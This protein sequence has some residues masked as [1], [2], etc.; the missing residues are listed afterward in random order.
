MAGCAR[1]G[2]A[3][4]RAYYP[5]SLCGKPSG[6]FARVPRIVRCPE[7]RAAYV[8]AYRVNYDLG[9]RGDVRDTVESEAWIERRLA[10]LD[11]QRKRPGWSA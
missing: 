8:R 4:N 3:V 11:R 5:C 2:E 10:L 1:A 9:E 7:H 6:P